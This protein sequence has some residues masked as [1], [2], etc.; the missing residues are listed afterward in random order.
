MKNQYFC[1]I[2]VECIFFMRER[3]D[4]H[5]TQVYQIPTVDQIFRKQYQIKVQINFGYNHV[6][7]YND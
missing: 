2:Y 5:C 6:L 7:I 1:V 4:L 3:Y